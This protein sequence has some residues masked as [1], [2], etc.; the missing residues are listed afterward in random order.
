MSGLSIRAVK[1]LKL[2]NKVIY[3][4]TLGGGVFR[5]LRPGSRNISIDPS[6]LLLLED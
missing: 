4:A 5:Y 6:L 3:V 1:D 2:N